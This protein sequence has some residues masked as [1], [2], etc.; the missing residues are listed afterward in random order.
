[1][2]LFGM[3]S[4][5]VRVFLGL[6]DREKVFRM[7]HVF[8]LFIYS[9]HISSQRLSKN[10]ILLVLFNKDINDSCTLFRHLNHD[11]VQVYLITLNLL[12]NICVK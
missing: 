1:M 2:R 5:C 11:L 3:F 4:P 10:I 6:Q 9:G 12:G 8:F 7:T